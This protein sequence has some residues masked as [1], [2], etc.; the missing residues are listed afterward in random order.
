MSVSKRVLEVLARTLFLSGET[1]SVS[2]TGKSDKRYLQAEKMTKQ[3]K[4]IDG[5][6]RRLY[7]GKDWSV[8]EK[9]FLQR[10]MQGAEIIFQ[11]R[12]EKRNNQDDRLVFCRKINLQREGQIEP[13]A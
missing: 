12:S 5:I 8:P 9:C 4:V 7:N 1:G 6:S 2:D 13:E 10:E 11:V 3:C